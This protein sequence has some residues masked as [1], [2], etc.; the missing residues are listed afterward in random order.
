MGFQVEQKDVREE[1]F[2]TETCRN[3]S[4]QGD[5]LLNFPFLVPD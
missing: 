1:I 2:L 5:V 4:A 3:I